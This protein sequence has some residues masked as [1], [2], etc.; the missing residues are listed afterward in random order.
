MCVYM[1]FSLSNMIFQQ[2]S[3]A[4][5]FFIQVYLHDIFC[6]INH[7]APLYPNII[8]PYFITHGVI[9]QLQ[10]C[11]PLGATE[12]VSYTVY[13]YIVWQSRPIFNF[14]CVHGKNDQ[15]PWMGFE[16]LRY[17][18][19]PFH[20]PVFSQVPPPPLQTILLGGHLSFQV[21]KGIVIEK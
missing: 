18:P 8:G 10:L 7:P 5:V 12:W 3:C 15:F 2:W 14:N 21:E 19:S 6:K 13:V 9:L 4:S 1:N 16:F 20:C 17:Y 11:I